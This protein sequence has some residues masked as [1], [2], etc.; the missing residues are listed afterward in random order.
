MPSRHRFNGDQGVSPESW[1]GFLPVKPKKEEAA[2]RFTLHRMMVEK[3]KLSAGASGGTISRRGRFKKS[4]SYDDSLPPAQS[5]PP[6]S[7]SRKMNCVKLS[8]LFER[9]AGEPDCPRAI[10][11][12]LRGRELESPLL[13]VR[14]EVQ[15]HGPL[16]EPL[17]LPSTRLA[18]RNRE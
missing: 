13:G 5:S 10:L 11:D 17:V 7:T 8:E 3:M 12:H 14:S 15:D 9:A 2:R 18:E 4:A 1:A 6:T 16:R